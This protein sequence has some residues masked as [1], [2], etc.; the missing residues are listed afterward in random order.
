M[1]V[2]VVA[3]GKIG[4]PLSVQIAA[5]GHTVVGVDI[6]PRVVDLVNEGREPF[7]GEAELDVRL[8][9]V[10]TAGSLRATTDFADAIPGAD[11]VV[12]VVPVVVDLDARPDFRAIDAAT[13]AIGTHLTA[14]TLVSYETTLPVH[15]TRQRFVP[16]LERASGLAPGRDFFVCHSPERVFTG[17]VFADLRKYPKLVGAVDEPSAARA[18]DFYQQVLDFD[19]RDDL[20]QPNGVWDLGSAEAAELAKLA[21]TTYRN[22]NIALANELALH[23]ESIGID[24][25]PVIDAANSQPFS[26]IHRPG[27]AVGGHCI[28]VYPKFYLSVDEQATLPAAAIELNES[29]P[30]RAA[31]ATRA[32]VGDLRGK[33]VAV[34]GVAYRGGVK[35]TAFSGAFPLAAA[36]REMG[37][38]VVAHDP[39]YDDDEL[40]SLGFEPHH[41]GDPCDAAVIQTDH[42]RYRDL[43]ADDLPGAAF[44][45]DGRRVVD[46]A[47]LAPIA[48]HVIGT[49]H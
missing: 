11:A 8:E 24:V 17:R 19:E 41:L 49:G 25:L 5:N 18:V 7:P 22:I 39:L 6:D 33:R 35:E 45:Y 38:E 37:A 48:V 32:H 47:R 12:V 43:R 34:L 28:P 1:N 26:H 44:V 30:R 4:L 27:I 15:T 9:A 29:M 23:A 2:T 20:P 13:E 14:G 21:E 3:L 10:V 42:D 46:A 16:G 31:E 40:T 36:L